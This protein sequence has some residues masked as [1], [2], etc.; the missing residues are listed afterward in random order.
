MNTLNTLRWFYRAAQC[1][2]EA[3]KIQATRGVRAA[4]YMYRNALACMM[5]AT[6]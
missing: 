5:E 1:N 6:R 4:E 3:R 2:K